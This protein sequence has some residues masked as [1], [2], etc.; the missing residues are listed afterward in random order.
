[1][2]LTCNVCTIYAVRQTRIVICTNHTNIQFQNI[3]SINLHCEGIKVPSLIER[4]SGAFHLQSIKFP[5]AL[6]SIRRGSILNGWKLFKFKFNPGVKR[7]N[8][9]FKSTETSQL[10]TVWVRTINIGVRRQAVHLYKLGL[11]ES[12]HP[13]FSCYNKALAT[14]AQEWLK[15]CGIPT[16]PRARQMRVK[17]TVGEERARRSVYRC[18]L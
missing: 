5:V 7:N 1:M 11:F 15:L 18:R 4:L 12:S 9:Y 16:I 10:H 14:F 6:P 17:L 2:A 13:V 3:S 8:F